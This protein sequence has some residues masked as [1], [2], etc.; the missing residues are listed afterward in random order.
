MAQNIPFYPVVDEENL[1][2][3]ELLLAQYW[4]DHYLKVIGMI[5]RIER[6]SIVHGERWAEGMSSYWRGR[7]VD[8]LEHAPAGIKFVELSDDDMVPMDDGRGT[9]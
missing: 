5:A 1:A 3:A 9:R 7:A 6:L 4:V 8:M 2:H